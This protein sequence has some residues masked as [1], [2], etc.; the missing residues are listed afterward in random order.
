MYWIN[1][2]QAA[3]RRLETLDLLGKSNTLEFRR[4][5]AWACQI[6]SPSERIIS[7]PMYTVVQSFV[8]I[9]RTA[10]LHCNIV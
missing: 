10:M 3:V 8:S 9:R 7:S 6:V 4:P 2:I 1:P 5:E